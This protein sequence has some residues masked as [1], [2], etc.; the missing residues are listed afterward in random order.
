[1]FSP[2]NPLQN[3]RKRYSHVFSPIKHSAKLVN[4]K[5][6][7]LV[8]KKSN[9]KLCKTK[10]TRPLNS[11]HREKCSARFKKQSLRV[12]SPKLLSA[13]LC[14]NKVMH[15]RKKKAAQFYR[16]QFA[17]HFARLFAEKSRCKKQQNFKKT[18]L[19]CFLRTFL[20]EKSKPIEE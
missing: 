14:K 11:L 18:K 2:K 16:N 8:D 20:S 17:V 4:T 7:D 13:K 15:C 12:K 1:M 6:R 3:F 19:A 9:V 10:F 5:F